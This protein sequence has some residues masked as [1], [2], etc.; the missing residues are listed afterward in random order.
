MITT[1]SLPPRIVLFAVVGAPEVGAARQFVREAPM[2]HEC[3]LVIHDC[4]R[5]DCNC[6]NDIHSKQLHSHGFAAAHLPRPPVLLLSQGGI[7]VSDQRLCACSQ[8]AHTG[9]CCACGA[10]CTCV[11]I[12]VHSSLILVSY[13]TNVAY[14]NDCVAQL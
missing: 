4:G 1:V 13:Y 10:E 3:G 11:P 9:C 6:N 8:S 7:D 14:T 5:G 12:T 2:Q